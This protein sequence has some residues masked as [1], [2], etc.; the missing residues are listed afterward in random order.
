M[1][2][3][4]Q[5]MSRVLITG[6][7]GYVGGR[8]AQHLTEIGHEVILG[9]RKQQGAPEWLAQA[10]VVVMQWEDEEALADVCCDVEVVIH[11]AGVNAQDCAAN[12]VAAL[13]FNGVATARLVQGSKRSGVN[14]FIY[15][16]TAHVYCSPL[17][18]E[19]DE[20]TCPTNLHPYATSHLAGEQALLSATQD[21]SEMAGIVLRLSNVIGRPA[22]VDANCW[23]LLVND[24]CK[25]AVIHQTM[26]IHGNPNDVRDFVAMSTLCETIACLIDKKAEYSTQIHNVGTGRAVTIQKMTELIVEQCQQNYGFFPNIIVTKQSNKIS[27]SL[28]YAAMPFYCAVK[29]DDRLSIRTEIDD[30]LNLCVQRY[31]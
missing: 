8:V 18:G 25:E 23:M 11:A 7:F 26:T 27:K 6:G 2:E 1:G 12:P 10:E 31:K 22:S 17:I 16:S 9:T 24:L 5:S 13:N 15:L 14:K 20:Q 4:S 19:I 29:D 21:D 3:L 30:L 28:S